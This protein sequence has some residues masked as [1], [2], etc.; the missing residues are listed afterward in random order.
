MM[1][2]AKEMQDNMQQMQADLAN[3][4]LLG[5]AGGGMVKVTMTGDR[6][7]KRS[8]IEDSLWAD[9]DKGLAEELIAAAFNMASKSADETAK[10]EQK[11]LMSGLPLPPGFSL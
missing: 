7:V 11:K 1:Q 3:V 8:E 6:M 5:E 9:S 4:E 2:K 10:E